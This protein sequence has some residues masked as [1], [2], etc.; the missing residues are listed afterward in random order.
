M[1][2]LANAL[3]Q[4]AQ[5]HKNIVVS[6]A[7]EPGEGEQKIMAYIRKH[8]P[9][10]SV[11]YGLD[12][13]LIILSL[14]TGTMTNTN[15]DLFRE[16]TEFNGK[17]KINTFDNE[18]FLYMNTNH[19]ADVLYT[20]YAKPV[21]DKRQFIYDFVGLMSLLGNDFV[22]HGMGLKIRENGIQTLMT[23]YKQCPQPIVDSISWTYN[24][25]SLINLFTF[26]EKDEES[27][28]L[29]AIQHKLEA[30][31]GSTA[32]KDAVEQALARYNDTPVIWAVEE[33]L[34]TKKRVDGYEKPLMILKENWKQSYDNFVYG[35]KNPTIVTQMYLESA[36]WTLKYYVGMPIDSW[37][38]YPW[39][40]PPRTSLILQW[41]KENK[42]QAPQTERTPL[43][44]K[45]QLAIVLP[46][47]SYYLLPSEYQ[48]IPK[49]LPY[50]FP[51]HWPQYSFGRRFMWECEP[52]IPLIHPLTLQ[53]A[54]TI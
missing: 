21:S 5:N 19:L 20:S 11:V 42:I 54:L 24:H 34:I 7:D 53:S 39:Y 23:Y 35:T 47:T 9:A 32:S 12:A 3:R 41:L 52:V 22:P 25:N 50:A 38:Y 1:T 43:D 14:I 31:V 27:L 15:V 48:S 18:E 37:F 30:R 33:S 44:P 36:A 2:K 13:D 28:I 16:E 46:E 51:T 29:K 45:H 10:N 6:P 4:Y 49:K 26:I 8:K 17:I 40:L